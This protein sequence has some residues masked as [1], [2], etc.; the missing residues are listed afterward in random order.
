MKP[1]LTKSTQPIS[2]AALQA[3]V[4]QKAFKLSQ[5]AN[6]EE[7]IRQS[8]AAAPRAIR[9]GVLN[10][11]YPTINEPVNIYATSKAAISE[12]GKQIAH[13]LP[14]ELAKTKMIG[15]QIGQIEGVIKELTMTDRTL[16]SDP[17]QQAELL[18]TM[19]ALHDKKMIT[20]SQARNLRSALGQAIAKG[21]GYRLP[22]ETYNTLRSVYKLVDD[23][24]T[25]AATAE[26]KLPQLR[27]ADK[28]YKQFMSDFY[29]KSAPLK[30]VLNFR[31]GMT[32]KTARQLLAPANVNR[33]IEALDRWGM[34]DQATALRKI[35]D[36]PNRAQAIKD[37][38]EMMVSPSGFK[39]AQLEMARTA[40]AAKVSESNQA[41]A[42]ARKKR[43]KLAAGA[44]GGG[45]ALYKGWQWMKEAGR[46]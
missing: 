4:T 22:A 39:N 29:N 33:A 44:V 27:H 19:Q 40:D 1:F 10:K 25:E 35:A 46:P 14:G 5:M 34:K 31:E 17:M 41:L 38:E 37:M 42:D 6:A 3:G 28:V 23:G 13:G 43:L 2:E 15:Q 45:T 11:L 9:S 32:G 16:A 21:Q 36:M 18:D 20:F 7:G 24:I 12:S 8:I 26:G 30:S